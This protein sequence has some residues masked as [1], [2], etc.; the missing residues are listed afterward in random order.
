MDK[1]F[2]RWSIVLLMLFTATFVRAQ[3]EDIQ[4]MSC[5]NPAPV[6]DGFSMYIPIPGSFWFT[7][8]TYD[9]PLHARFTVTGEQFE[10]V[11]AYVDFGCVTGQYGDEKLER[12]VTTADG[13]GVAVPMEFPFE[14]TYNAETGYTYYDLV[15]S[16]SYRELL[17]Q[18]G[19]TYNVMAYV[20]IVTQRFGQAD[21]I[22]DDSFR[23]CIER[24][25]WMYMPDTVVIS[26][27]TLDSIFTFPFANWQS[28][29]VRLTW[30][31]EK[32]KTILY[33]G[34]TCDFPLDPAD[35]SI[36]DTLHIAP[37]SYRDLSADYI[38]RLIDLNGKGGIYYARMLTTDS[39]ALI[40]APKPIEGPLADAIPMEKDFTYPIAADDTTQYYYFLKSWE[41][42]PLRFHAP[43]SDPITAFFGTTPDFY[44]S[45]A[46]SRYLGSNTFTLAEDG[47][48]LT[49]SLPE[50]KQYTRQGDMD[51]T[52]VRFLTA[53][54][55]TITPSTWAT[56]DCVGSTVLLDTNAVFD[57]YKTQAYP[58][59]RIRYADWVQHDMDF[60]L[61]GLTKTYLYV[62]D[63]CTFTLASNNLHVLFYQNFAAKDTLTLTQDTLR[64]M[65]S[66]VDADGYLYIQFMQG[67]TTG[68]MHVFPHPKKEGPA[69]AV[70]H[71]A[72]DGDIR[73][74]HLDHAWAI[75]TP[76]AQTLYL[77]NSL[78]ALVAT[79]QQAA[80]EPKILSAPASGIYI[81]RGEKKAVL[82]K[83]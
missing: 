27:S 16:E 35:M 45:S 44:I 61:N 33:F 8:Y 39:A 56:S 1:L 22:P 71:T 38:S 34:N 42:K 49:L 46:D 54:P 66:R 7:A 79:W 83:K 15:I 75:T 4:G 9:L 30:T 37:N 47:Q 23:S 32:Q 57:M 59:Y 64:S 55:T 21:I 26:Q 11:K 25:K 53:T 20:N 18:F 36:V 14:R 2:T 43:S 76:T 70:T 50:L 3:Y 6:A 5:E 24:S 77:Y 19:I 31:G 67:Q 40:V 80:N 58:T 65:E 51:Y 48:E 78:G 17:A 72:A 82:L 74:A 69:T 12:V 29:S 28:D 62:G 41:E 73:V 81:L 63:T 60:C 52:F 68:E 13:W 10:P